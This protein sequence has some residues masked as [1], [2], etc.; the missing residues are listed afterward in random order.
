MSPNA[1][2]PNAE[3]MIDSTVPMHTG[4]LKTPLQTKQSD[5]FLTNRKRP[6]EQPEMLTE[7]ETIAQSPSSLMQKTAPQIPNS[8]RYCDQSHRP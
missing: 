5:D 1:N 3:T 4:Q 8:K 2:V 7:S 6:V